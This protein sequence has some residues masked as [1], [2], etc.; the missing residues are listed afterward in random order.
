MVRVGASFVSNTGNGERRRR[1]PP[2]ARRRRHHSSPSPP[3]HP[4]NRRARGRAC[5]PASICVVLVASSPAA[6]SN[7]AAA[8]GARVCAR[9]QPRGGAARRGSPR[10]FS[11]MYPES[12]A[13]RVGR[14][15]VGILLVGQV[16]ARAV[17]FASRKSF[18][19][20]G[21]GAVG[22]IQR[23]DVA[24]GVDD[25]MDG[26]RGCRVRRVTVVEL[27]RHA[28]GVARSSRDEVG[29]A[30]ASKMPAVTAGTS[31]GAA[32]GRGFP[33]PRPPC[34]RGDASRRRG[35]C[36]AWTVSDRR[37][38]DPRNQPRRDGACR[39]DRRAP[40]VR[41]SAPR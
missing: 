35:T 15:R 21:R 28:S 40:R 39:D 29:C 20:V 7:P 5:L 16:G 4:P 19:S 24:H 11:G 34:A 37:R 18:G 33:P 36:A 17:F 22:R 1:A 32:R 38:R 30:H 27:M 2:N 31:S 8:G 9:T 3:R 25:G 41:P 6:V 14:W 12:H 23:L 26:G 13:Y 10:G